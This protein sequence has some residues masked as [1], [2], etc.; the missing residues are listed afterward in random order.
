MT[1]ATHQ[2][3]QSLWQR[4]VQD[5]LGGLP[6]EQRRNVERQFEA[7]FGPCADLPDGS[8]IMRPAPGPKNQT[9]SR[10]RAKT[11]S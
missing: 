8:H 3:I 9:N 6:V 1:L 4:F 5:E 11:M 7:R 10:K 2:T